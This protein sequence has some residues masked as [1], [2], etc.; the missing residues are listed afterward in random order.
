MFVGNV[1]IVGGTLYGLAGGPLDLRGSAWEAGVQSAVEQALGS[2]RAFVRQFCDPT[3]GFC[4]GHP[5]EWLPFFPPGGGVGFAGPAGT[6]ASSVNIWVQAFA[7]GTLGEEHAGVRDL[8]T[9]YKY[10]IVRASSR[11]TRARPTRREM[12]T[13]LSTSFQPGVFWQ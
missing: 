10:G 2:G 1:A 4:I 6:E 7:P 9:L 5:L 3:A 12:A 8:I 13:L 11:L